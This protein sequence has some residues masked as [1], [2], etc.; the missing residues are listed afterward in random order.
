MSEI[1]IE[2]TMQTL[3]SYIILTTEPAT[4]KKKSNGN[5][6]E[7]CNNQT[8]CEILPPIQVTCLATTGCGFKHPGANP[9]T[10]PL[11]PFDVTVPSTP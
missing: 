7:L 8:G 4:P 3:N 1:V 10:V 5:K 11:Q 6:T 2:A 9:A